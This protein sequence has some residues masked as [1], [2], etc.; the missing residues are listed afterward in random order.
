MTYYG[1]RVSLPKETALLSEARLIRGAT[2]AA[3]GETL[4]WEGVDGTRYLVKTFARK[5]WLSRFL[6]GRLT[7]G[8]EWRMLTELC[9]RGISCAPAPVAKIGRYTIVMEYIEGEQLES[10]AH[11]RRLSQTPPHRNFFVTLKSVLHELH[12]AGFAHGDFRR[13]NILVQRD[14]TPRVIDWA[15]GVLATDWCHLLHRQFL[16]SDD[17]SLVK[18]LPGY[19]DDLVTEEEIQNTKPGPLLRL[20]RFLRQN[21]YRKLKRR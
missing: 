20:G 7:I 6:F 5:G 1:E 15:T 10:P 4:C 16:R 12:S 13:A 19:Y 21:I 8:N 11:Y 18:L 9:R 17:L 2:S 14:G 3:T